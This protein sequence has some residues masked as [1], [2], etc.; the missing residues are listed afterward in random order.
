MVPI[1]SIEATNQAQLP[2]APPEPRYDT[3]KTGRR[4]VRVVKVPYSQDPMKEKTVFEFSG[5]V[6]ICY[7]KKTRGRSMIRCLGMSQLER[8]QK[9]VS[10]YDAGKI[11]TKAEDDMG[12]AIK[13][14]INDYV[15]QK[16][17]TEVA[18]HG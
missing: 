13:E 2:E 10:P 17:I 6:Y 8:E 4:K 14:A 12:E 1:E 5:F 3:E 11:L 7:A 18:G 9:P 15:V 16:V